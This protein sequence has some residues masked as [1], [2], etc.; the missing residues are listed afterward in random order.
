VRFR[1]APPYCLWSA[2][3]VGFSRAAVEESVS[4]RAVVRQ[5]VKQVTEVLDLGELVTCPEVCEPGIAFAT[6]R[7]LFVTVGCLKAD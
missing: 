3:C 7:L 5:S 2:S 6:C 4:L 1:G